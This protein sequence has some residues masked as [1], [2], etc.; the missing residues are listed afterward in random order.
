MRRASAVLILLLLS[1][2]IVNL[3]AAKPPTWL[4]LPWWQLML[5]AAAL[6]GAGE[7]VGWRRRAAGPDGGPVLSTVDEDLFRRASRDLAATVRQQWTE[8]AAN[9]DLL[10]PVPLRVTWSATTWP[11]AAPDSAVLADNVG[12]TRT[13]SIS[14]GDLD[15][16][17]AEF[18]DLPRQLVVLGSPGSGKT[19]F[20]VTF[21][22]ALLRSWQDGDPIPVPISVASWD[23][24]TEHLLTM[25]TRQLL[26]AYP[27]LNNVSVYGPHA[28]RQLVTTGQVLAV[29]DGLDEM[30][31]DVHALALE[32]I[33]RAL[34]NGGSLLLTCRTTEYIR[35]VA[36]N[37]GPLSAA[38]VI[39]LERVDTADVVD[40]LQRAGLAPQ[41]RW[42]PVI[43][44]LHGD[45]SSV[46]ATALSTP[47]MVWLLRRVY[48][49]P[50]TNPA[51]LLEARFDHIEAVE[52]HLLDALIPAL[53]AD[54]PPHPLDARRHRRYRPERALAH[55]RFLAGHLDGLNTT[56]LAWWELHKAL[57]GPSS[58][59]TA[60]ACA[61]VA[62]GVWVVAGFPYALAV[63][64]M[65]AL[66]ARLLAGL[67]GRVRFS[68]GIGL[69]MGLAIGASFGMW[70]GFTTE[71][72]AGQDPLAYGLG[73]GLVLGVIV[74]LAA[75]ITV[76]YT[77]AAQITPTQFN[78]D[79]RRRI[80]SLS[81][82]L[83]ISMFGGLSGGVIGGLAAAPEATTANLIGI[84]LMILLIPALIVWLLVPWKAGPS[85][86]RR[87]G[88]AVGTVTGLIAGIVSGTASGITIGL[89]TGITFGSV[90]GLAQWWRA[91]VD[92]LRASSP[93]S[94]FR[95]DASAAIAHLVLIGVAFGPLI[96]Y[97][98]GQGYGSEAGVISGFVSWFV[99]GLLFGLAPHS[100]TGYW[101]T[102]G[103]LAVRG[104]IPWRL[105]QFVD[106]AHR[107][108]VFRQVG[109][110]YQ[111]RHAL[112]QERLTDPERQRR[113]KSF[114]RGLE[115]MACGPTRVPAPPRGSRRSR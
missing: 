88:L 7:F 89:M 59:V 112:L 28:A 38:A 13:R 104:R 103:W 39:E 105:M 100:V 44:H 113:P 55:L 68:L 40:F 18:R 25:I 35:A 37:A 75:S 83:S 4:D 5:I 73:A 63:T 20:A 82:N 31:S 53:Y 50:I 36:A 77:L 30:A 52:R 27:A 51:E 32:A 95:Q 76:G 46:L 42:R 67:P 12:P 94:I 66:V 85:M 45:A 43:D 99:F 10:R 49:A 87:F 86:S 115:T 3:A 48:A 70:I 79:G 41:E 47:L 26:S 114:D 74:G 56:D 17:V 33:D 111:F 60:V 80:R 96:G 14:S 24:G 2:W 107:R 8:E 29:L 84:V 101:V 57:R 22:L 109:G 62:F 16:V 11:I 98:Y 71:P 6:A 34:A 72:D 92:V 97:F 15:D 23:P 81:A 69:S 108:G 9:R 19:V 93:R 64:T 91:P 58:I 106:D 54:Q 90:I 1:G 78:P 102:V 61:L 65:C 110:V 21:T